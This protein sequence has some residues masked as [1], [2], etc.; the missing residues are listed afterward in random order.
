MTRRALLHLALLVVLV[1]FYAASVYVAL[2]PRVSEHYHDYYISRSTT[3]WNPERGATR[4]ADGFEFSRIVYPREVDYVRGLGATEPWGRWSDARMGSSVSILL[5]EPLSGRL[6]VDVTLK[7]SPAQIGA[8][9]TVRIGDRTATLVLPDTEPRDERVDVELSRPVR[10]I[11]LEPS[12]A[13]TGGG[14]GF[15]DRGPKVGIGLIRLRVTQGG[16]SG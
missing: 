16:C 13:A 4:L 5:R 12:R 9:V 10:R 14:W 2:H 15:P 6:C 8:P 11:D 7:A 3:D 1:I